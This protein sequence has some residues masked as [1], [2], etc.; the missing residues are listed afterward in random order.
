MNYLDFIV[1]PESLKNVT[2]ADQVK[3]AMMVLIVFFAIFLGIVNQNPT[4][5]SFDG[6]PL[7]IV[8]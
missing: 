7:G 1:L 8:R 6:L 2:R 3:M 4:Y 5:P